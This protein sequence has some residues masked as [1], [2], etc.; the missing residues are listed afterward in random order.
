MLFFVFILKNGK[1]LMEK[2][3]SIPAKM[4][5]TSNINKIA[6]EFELKEDCLFAVFHPQK[7]YWINKYDSF[8]AERGYIGYSNPKKRWY[9]RFCPRES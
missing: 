1:Y 9:K 7:K 2:E 4:K 6:S 8:I 5:T 3:I